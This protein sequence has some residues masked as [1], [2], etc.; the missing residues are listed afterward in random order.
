MWVFY[1]ILM[2]VTVTKKCEFNPSIQLTE[3]YLVGLNAKSTTNNHVFFVSI[4]IYW[5]VEL[6]MRFITLDYTVCYLYIRTNYIIIAFSTVCFISLP[7][8]VMAVL[9]SCL[10]IYYFNFLFLNIFV[11][12][13]NTSFPTAIW[14]KKMEYYTKVKDSSY[15]Q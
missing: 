11:C 15:K 10:L 7:F 9:W 13:L 5:N 3:Y 2:S 6:K 1:G 4:N 14:P 8:L 12:H